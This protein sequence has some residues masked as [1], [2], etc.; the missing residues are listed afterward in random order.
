MQTVLPVV[1][2]GSTCWDDE[3]LPV[4][5]FEH[6]LRHVRLEMIRLGMDG[7]VIYGDRVDYSLLTYLTHYIPK[8]SSAIL[9]VPVVG[10]PTMIAKVAGTR[11]IP[12]IRQLT[13]L[14]DLRTANNIKKDVQEFYE[15]ISAGGKAVQI[16]AVGL[17]R[18]KQ[19]MYQDVMAGLDTETVPSYDSEFEHLLCQK[20]PREVA[21]MREAASI[22]GSSVASMKEAMSRGCGVVISVLEAERTARNLGAQ[23]VRI[24]YSLDRG[25]TF[26]PFIT[27]SEVRND[28][29]V[30]YF[31]VEFRGYW[32][33][34]MVSLTQNERPIDKTARQLLAFLEK[35][36]VPGVSIPDIVGKVQ[37]MVAPYHL[38]RLV[39][40][41]FGHAIGLSVEEQPYLRG[42]AGL[43]VPDSA[44]DS[45]IE[46]NQVYSIYIGLT[47]GQSE[48][49]LMSRMVLVQEHQNEILWSEHLPVGGSTH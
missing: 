5:E 27:T 31:A 3:R 2:H 48:N 12:S 40:G 18:M 7:L 11:D 45:I 19:P 33:E 30:T 42:T 29:L 14:A 24:L 28:P 49:S 17:G 1:L 44:G 43:Y 39:Q 36:L 46:K 4:D 32:A 37:T 9:L 38:H 15:N 6:R 20:R 35:S 16:G 21:V 47:D 22:L 10:E 23:D 34:G 8:H 13:W 26:E 25:Q 41:G